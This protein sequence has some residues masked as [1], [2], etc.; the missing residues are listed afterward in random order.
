MSKEVKQQYLRESILNDNLD[1]ESF[2]M[3]MEQDQDKGADLDKYD[4]EELKDKV[5]KFKQ[6]YGKGEAP[7]EGD[8]LRN[9]K[10]ETDKETKPEPAKPAARKV[11]AVQNKEDRSRQ[12]SPGSRKGGPD[13]DDDLDLDDKGKK[14]DNDDEID[15]ENRYYG[16]RDCVKLEATELLVETPVTVVVNDLSRSK[17]GAPKGENAIFVIETSPQGWK[18]LRTFK[19]FSW[20]HKCLTGNYPGYYLPAL[21][22]KKGAKKTDD[23]LVRERLGALQLFLNQILHSTE[24]KYSVDLVK[25]LKENDNAF[26]SYSEVRLACYQ[27]SRPVAIDPQTQKLH[28]KDS[29]IDNTF[30]SGELEG[31]C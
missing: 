30:Q 5:H 21:P 18:V 29:T 3:F 14:F 31:I 27:E 16:R 11:T 13:I 10:K 12:A 1:T 9:V 26:K 2:V 28:P 7:L 23:E 17:A 6:T 20:L 24:F 15:K 19:D 25:F 8:L 4:M 22:K